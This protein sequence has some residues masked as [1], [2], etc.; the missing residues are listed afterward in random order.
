MAKKNKKTGE[1]IHCSEYFPSKE[2]TS[3]NPYP[4]VGMPIWERGWGWRI[5][6]D[7]GL[8]YS[9]SDR[10]VIGHL[11]S[12]RSIS[13]NTHGSDFILQYDYSH[14]DLPPKMKKKYDEEEYYEFSDYA[15]RRI[16]ANQN[17]EIVRSSPESYEELKIPKNIDVMDF[18]RLINNLRVEYSKTYDLALDFF[19][20]NTQDPPAVDLSI[21]QKNTD[22]R[23]TCYICGE[24]LKMVPGILPG[25]N[26]NYCP[27]CE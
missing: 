2:F 6:G 26:H 18:S 5:V 15:I 22:G 10:R 8:L 1:L 14:L 24:R 21:K 4:F 27:R 13:T 7:G 16:A 11:G 9:H 20:G 12:Y 19:S 23:A 17:V 3:S 25:N